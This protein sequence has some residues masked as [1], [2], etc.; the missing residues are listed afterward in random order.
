[1]AIPCIL[2][3]SALDERLAAS[4]RQFEVFASLPKP[5]SFRDITRVVAEAL[6]QRP[7]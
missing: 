2:L 5:V 6:L 3:S 7:Q 4:A 1:M